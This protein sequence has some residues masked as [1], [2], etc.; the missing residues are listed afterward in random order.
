MEH[1]MITLPLFEAGY[2]ILLATSIAMSRGFGLMTISPIFVRL[3][4]TGP[5]RSG[6]ALA[7]SIPVIPEVMRTL[8]SRPPMTIPWLG[9]MMLK[10]FVIGFAI[11][12]LFSIPFWAAEIAG[13]LIDLQRGSTSAQL[14]DPQS[15][16]ETSITGTFFALA[17]IVLFF[18][19][20]GFLVLLDSFYNSYR[21]WPVT[22]FVPVLT[23]ATLP[24]FI[25]TVNGMMQMALVQIGPIVLALL[26]ADLMLAFLSRMAPQLHVFDLSMAVKNLI[27]ALL[28]A[29]YAVFLIPQMQTELG[30]LRQNVDAFFDIKPANMK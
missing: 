29:L 17:I 18:S 13:D 26:I 27:F 2:A 6:V 25:G 16:T 7:I 21:I 10:E 14:V 11:G 9:A 12:F 30:R 19:S 4:I 20:G 3:G 28:I 24:L 1:S 8:A 22:D 23:G 5:I 15:V